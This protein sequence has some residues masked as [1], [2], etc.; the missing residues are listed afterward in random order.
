MPFLSSQAKSL[1]AK[2]EEILMLIGLIL[3]IIFLIAIIGYFLGITVGSIIYD[4]KNWMLYLVG[5]V[6][7]MLLSDFIR[8]KC[9]KTSAT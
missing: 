4:T 2:C 6:L 8:H 1:L 5:S 3:T 9:A 7:G